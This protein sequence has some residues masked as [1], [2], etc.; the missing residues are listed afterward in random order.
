MKKY[1]KHEKITKDMRIIL[2]SESLLRGKALEILGL[3]FEKIPSHIDEDAIQ[4]KDNR[5]R[6]RM[7]AEAKAAEIAR[8]E[9]GAIII[10]GDLITI[11]EGKVLEKPK[12]IEEAVQMFKFFSGKE[13]EIIAG[14]CVLNTETKKILS[15]SDSYK[16]KWRTL[17][18]EEI[19]DY[20]RRYPVTKFAA[21]FEGDALL[22]FGESSNG[23]Y[24]F[25]TGL[26]MKQLIEFLRANGIK[27]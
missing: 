11:V 4:D 2:A 16:V 22:R 13:M 12:D 23:P 24:P 8:R 25:L 21:A 15:I 14:L 3:K 5:K 20:C 6:V 17:N 18:E 27:I 19:R 10:S 1:I 9:K 7:L 26:P